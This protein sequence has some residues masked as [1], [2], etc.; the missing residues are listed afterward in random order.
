MSK[1]STALAATTKK[2][3]NA[4]DLL[5]LGLDGKG[6]QSGMAAPSVRLRKGNASHG[7]DA[8]V[9]LSERTHIQIHTHKLE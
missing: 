7:W 1:T 2:K 4:S 9:S 8:L 3:G 5:Q 6:F